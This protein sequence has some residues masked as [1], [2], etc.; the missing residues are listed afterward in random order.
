MN[1]IKGYINYD[2]GPNTGAYGKLPGGIIKRQIQLKECPY[3]P[4]IKGGCPKME[5]FRDEGRKSLRT[6]FQI[7][8]YLDVCSE[9][10][11]AGCEEKKRLDNL[12]KE[13]KNQKNKLE[14]IT[15]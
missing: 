11:G 4:S 10:Y 13:E 8:Q 9:N 6:L 1:S 7:N 5:N 15:Y 2:G 3:L 12:K 14:K